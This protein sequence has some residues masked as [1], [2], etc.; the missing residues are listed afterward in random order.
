MTSPT[1]PVSEPKP[2]VSLL[3]WLSLVPIIAQRLFV[4]G[5][6]FFALIDPHLFPKWTRIA[7]LL[8]CFE[9][10]MMHSGMFM[11][12]LP[13]AAN[14][15]G[16]RFAGLVVFFVLALIY[17]LFAFGFSRGGKEPQVLYVFAGV[18]LNRFLDFLNHAKKAPIM[19]GIS[20]VSAL[21]WL[22]LIFISSTVFSG[23]QK[24]NYEGT[25]D[26]QH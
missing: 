16:N 1:N 7:P 21:L 5:I 18:T 12:L 11:V 14:A 9:F 19:T 2:E 3:S 22:P 13:A 15:K 6:F 25:S 20:A 4:I 17:M 23:F 10:I 26:S 24:A 8:F